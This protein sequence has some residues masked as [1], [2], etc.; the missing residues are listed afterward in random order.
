MPVAGLKWLIKTDPWFI[1]LTKTSYV[2]LTSIFTSSRRIPTFS[3]LS[4]PAPPGSDGSRTHNADWPT[5]FFLSRSIT[6]EKSASE[7]LRIF[8]MNINWAVFWEPLP[9]RTRFFDYFPLPAYTDPLRYARRRRS[10]SSSSSLIDHKYFF[11][12][13]SIL[14]FFFVRNTT[15]G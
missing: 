12:N 2:T 14:D 5:G 15:S 13:L 10:L 11:S 3:D 7:M 8:R 1:L 9:K 4:R 6:H